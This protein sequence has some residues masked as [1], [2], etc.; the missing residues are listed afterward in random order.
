MFMEKPFPL[1]AQALCNSTLVWVSKNS[2]FQSLDANPLLARKLITG[3]SV[4]LHRLVQ[5]HEFN[6][7]RSGKQRVADYLLRC[8]GVLQAEGTLVQLP[9]NKLTIAAHLGVT[10]EHFSRILHEM[11]DAGLID[12]QGKNILITD[13]LKLKELVAELPEAYPGPKA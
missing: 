6:S 12:V 1:S 10:P 13:L 11:S 8:P 7:M 3:L 9:A 4:R 2:I 5:N